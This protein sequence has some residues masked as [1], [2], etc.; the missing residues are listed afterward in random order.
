LLGVLVSA[1]GLSLSQRREAERQRDVAVAATKRAN[2][3]ADFAALVMEQVGNQPL[4]AREI[5]DRARDGMERQ[6]S[7]DSGFLVSALVQLSDR[8]AQLDEVP[9]RATL[10]ARAES[11]AT[12]MH[13]TTQLAE[14]RCNIGD[15]MRLQGR[16]EDSERA[17]S[18]G[19]ALLRR[20][21]DAN[22]EASCLLFRTML[23]NE[24]SKPEVSAP[25]IYRALAIRDS[26]GER[27]D[28]FYVS[29]LDQ[30]GYT[31]DRQD[32]WRE[33]LAA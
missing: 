21:P 22:A 17:I 19:L 18:D 10:L 14:V 30:L 32:R 28:L 15:N 29:L 6:F 4:T 3:Q 20:A 31:L 8:Y 16:Q 5:L 1:T 26:V 7:A 11:I 27:R 33:G 12:A 24:R 2:A 9:V 25:A 23:A 13:D